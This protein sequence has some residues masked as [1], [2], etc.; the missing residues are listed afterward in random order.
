MRKDQQNR[1]SS[2]AIEVRENPEF[3]THV[4]G[5]D[6][7]KV[8]INSF[9][10]TETKNIHWLLQ[11]LLLKFKSTAFKAAKSGNVEGYV[12][13]IKLHFKAFQLS[14]EDPE[15][16]PLLINH[17][18]AEPKNFIPNEAKSET[19]EPHKHSN[20]RQQDLAWV[21]VEPIMNPGS[22]PYRKKP[23]RSTMNT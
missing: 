14:L 10:E 20:F 3:V 8:S 18:E 6:I 17:L 13:I 15:I 19:R 7:T 12:T 1:H 22:H 21:K 5:T 2:E 4:S 11:K 23:G 9:D 16:F